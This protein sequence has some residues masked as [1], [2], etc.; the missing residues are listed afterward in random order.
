MQLLSCY[1]SAFGAIEDTTINLNKDLTTYCKENGYGKTTLA[2]FIKSMFYGLAK[3]KDKSYEREHYLPFNKKL[4]SGNI[5]F[6]IKDNHYKIE[7]VFGKTKKDDEVKLY[8]NGSEEKLNGNEPG[9]VIFGLDCESFER[10]IFLN[11]NSL[12]VKTTETINNQ[13]SKYI[14]G[15]SDD[16]SLNKIISKLE[17]KMKEIKPLKSSDVKGEVALT[18]RAIKHYEQE[19]DDL[20]II[21]KELELKY[22]KLDVMKTE[23]NEISLKIKKASDVNERN[24]LWEQLDKYALEIKEKEQNI[25]S[26][27]RKYHGNILSD[28]SLITLDETLYKY[29]NLINKKNS[30][31]INNADEEKLKQYNQM[32]SGKAI[33]QDELNSLSLKI[34]EYEKAKALSKMSDNDMRILNKYRNN[35]PNEELLTKINQTY[36]EYTNLKQTELESEIV[37]EANKKSNHKIIFLILGLI[38]ILL[39]G[40]LALT[41]NLAFFVLSILGIVLLILPSY[42]KTSNQDKVNREILQREQK[43]LKHKESIAQYEMKLNTYIMPYGFS[44]VENQSVDAA[45]II[46]KNELESY[47]Q[48]IDKYSSYKE[49]IEKLENELNQ[50]LLKYS[51]FRTND[52]SRVLNEVIQ[53]NSKYLYLIKEKE[54]Q[55][56]LLVQINEELNKCKCYLDEIVQKYNLSTFDK[57]KEF[58]DE[59]IKDK[60]LLNEYRTSLSLLKEKYEKFREEKNL[61]NRAEKEERLDLKELTLALDKISGEIKQLEDNIFQGETEIE[62]ID[63]INNLLIEENEKLAKLNHDYVILSKTKEYLEIA[64]V[65]LKNKYISPLKQSFTKYAD[66]LEKT[67]GNKIEIS[68]DFNLSIIQDGVKRDY[69]HLS[70]GQKTLVALSYILALIDNV[71]DQMN[72]F[73]IIDDLFTELDELHLIEAKKFIKNLS[74]EKQIIYFTCHP[75]RDIE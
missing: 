48:I 13:I 70:S 74:K 54:K 67:L 72:P 22:Q 40:A 58:K 3:P 5:E 75:S 66:V 36:Q 30:L 50:S 21:S 59:V 44:S 39:G 26:I 31:Q 61:Y 24:L 9:E 57:V 42:L 8:I 29:N 46:F 28:D 69:R 37:V 6:L 15:T 20:N 34:K 18:T 45:L 38:M 4:C 11:S 65:S 63:S 17:S 73:L 60:A 41:V 68:S 62:K 49:L 52:Y 7:R 14:K 1:I 25:E 35:Y 10:L 55:T 33:S 71:F 19:L 43:L 47:K 53:D 16:S 23:K 51:S 12:D 27:S 32:F 56:T 64:D 2:I